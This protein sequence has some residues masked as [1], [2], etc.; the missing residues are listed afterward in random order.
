M[1]GSQAVVSDCAVGDEEVKDT[2]SPKN[3]PAP[4][5]GG[6]VIDKSPE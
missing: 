3:V 5:A 2:M 6:G 1:G 4:E